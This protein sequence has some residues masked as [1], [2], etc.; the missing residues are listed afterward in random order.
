MYPTSLHPPGDGWFEL[1]SSE[2]AGVGDLGLSPFDDEG[3]GR[4]ERVV[5]IGDEGTEPRPLEWSNINGLSLLAFF[6]GC[7][8]ESR[9]G[10]LY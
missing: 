6:S 2:K 5:A 4:R 9:L 10:F 3:L 7:C 1:K 8:L